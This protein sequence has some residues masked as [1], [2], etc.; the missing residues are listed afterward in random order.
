MIPRLFQTN[1]TFCDELVT[2]SGKTTLQ[3]LQDSS[4]WPLAVCNTIPS[5]TMILANEH[6]VFYDGMIQ[7]H[8]SQAFP[9]FGC[10]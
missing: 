4:L 10:K 2:V 6:L 1:N 8:D 5:L 3:S 7:V 9:V